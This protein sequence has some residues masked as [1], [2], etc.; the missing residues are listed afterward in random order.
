MSNRHMQSSPQKQEPVLSRLSRFL[1]TPTSIASSDETNHA[2]LLLLLILVTIGVSLLIAFFWQDNDSTL[3]PLLLPSLFIIYGLTRAGFYRT[4]KFLLITLATLYNLLQIS[5]YSQPLYTPIL[6]LTIIGTVVLAAFLYNRYITILIAAINLSLTGGM[7]LRGT[8]ASLIELTGALLFILVIVF[9]VIILLTDWQ[10]RLEREQSRRETAEAEAGFYRDLLNT[11]PLMISLQSEGQLRYINRRGLDLLGVESAD[12]ALDRPVL[13]FIESTDEQTYTSADWQ[14]ASSPDQLMVRGNRTYRDMAGNALPVYVVA[15]PFQ[16]DGKLATL[17]IARPVIEMAN[18]SGSIVSSRIMRA[19][20][21]QSDDGIVLINTDLDTGPTIATANAAFCRL[22]GYEAADLTDKPLSSVVEDTDRLRALLANDSKLTQPL[23][24]NRQDGSPYPGI[25]HILPLRDEAG[26]CLQY[27]LIQR[28]PDDMLLSLYDTFADLISEQAFVLD[29]TPEG[30]YQIVQLIG[31]GPLSPYESAGRITAASWQSIIHP[32]DLPGLMTALSAVYAGEKQEVTFRYNNDDGSPQRFR[33]TF[34]IAPVQAQTQ[35]QKRLY[36]VVRDITRASHIEEMQRSH[37]VQLAVV[38]ELGLLAMADDSLQNLLRNTLILCEQILQTSAGDILRYQADTDSFE[39]IAHIC[40]DEIDLTSHFPLSA[41]GSQPDYAMRSGLPIISPDISSEARFQPLPYLADMAIHSSISMM[42]PGQGQPYG[43]LSLHASI[44]RDFTRDDLYFLQSIANILGTFA[45]RY[46]IHQMEERQRSY[47]EALKEISAILN[48]TLELPDVLAKILEFLEHVVPGHDASSIFLRQD[49]ET[50]VFTFASSR[51]YEHTNLTDVVFTLDNPIIQQMMQSRKAVILPDTHRQ[52]GWQTWEGT[53]WISSYVGAPIFVEDDCIALLHLDSKEINAFSDEDAE[54]LQAFVNSIGIAIQNA[55]HAEELERRVRERTDELRS[56]QQQLKTILNATGEGIF[57][58]ENNI[59][60]FA[61]RAFYEMTGYTP[62]KIIGQDSR[63][64][65]PDEI[66]PE[67]ITSLDELRDHVITDGIW[68]D[69]ARLQRQDGSTFSAGLTVSRLA[70]SDDETPRMVT[71]I[72]DISQ[73]KRLEALKNTFIASAAHELRNPIASLNTRIY[74]LRKKPDQLTHNID[75]MDKII[76]R[77]N[78]LVSDLLDMATLERGGIVLHQQVMILQ[79]I[80]QDVCLLQQARADEKGIILTQDI[81]EDPI[82][83]LVD[84][85]R[86]DQVFTNLIINALN[87]T[88]PGGQVQVLVIPDD[89][90]QTV[91][92]K[93]KDTGSGIAPDDLT[94]IFQPFFRGNR[95]EPDRPA[96]TG[97][98]L[99]ISHEI[100]T[101][102]DGTI[103]VES[104]V[105]VG[106]CFRVA[107]PIVHSD[108]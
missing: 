14:Q 104:E 69:T 17:E 59:I 40:P 62:D 50:D 37:V 12:S 52:D 27:A 73:Q 101:L 42:I 51:G 21:E 66:N 87:Y 98:G 8:E 63:V 45:E 13:N 106:S 7:L 64:L 77:M 36:G 26:T 39:L 90:S 1:I 57:Y 108:D 19:L 80:L 89:A 28:Q 54:R 93:V 29:S 30:D 44:E 31:S 41:P 102:H 35:G 95:D 56:E 38:A 107:L 20:F 33:L 85:V 71:L 94:F 60:V 81:P 10:L 53:T 67:E 100:I 76:R 11:A 6:L 92:I 23:T 61:N 84:P 55:R 32:D 25:W 3:L 88:P 4:G 16:H 97:L 74:H 46:R 48:S 65:R 18:R 24:V 47:A 79:T 99:S 49:T 2:R 96:G 82:H 58:T 105:D 83:V 70:N 22:T 91:A 78:R 5:V 75:L 86:L 43:V 103:D 68:R 72:R 34:Q 9:L 15:L